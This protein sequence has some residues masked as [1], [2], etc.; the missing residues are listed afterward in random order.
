MPGIIRASNIKDAMIDLISHRLILADLS[1]VLVYQNLLQI[2]IIAFGIC[3]RG[4][5]KDFCWALV[6]EIKKMLIYEVQL[7]FGRGCGPSYEA[8]VAR[9]QI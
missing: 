8:L 1:I 5:N 4:V 6:I 2:G 3:P 9:D 7:S